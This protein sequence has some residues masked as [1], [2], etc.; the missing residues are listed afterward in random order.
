MLP[1]GTLSFD[2]APFSIAGLE[3]RPFPVCHDSAFCCGFFLTGVDGSIGM[4][5]NGKFLADQFLAE[6]RRCSTIIVKC[7]YEEEKLA[8]EFSGGELLL[9][10]AVIGDVR[11]V[12]Y[13]RTCQAQLG[14][15]VD[16]LLVP[17]GALYTQNGATGVVVVSESAQNFVPVTVHRQENGKAYVSPVQTGLLTAGQTVRLF[18]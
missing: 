5:P 7:G 17:E 3:L 8:S 2:P 6:W 4:V 10:L 1:R 11:D 16:C 14:E 13:M 9:R 12:L 18:K 15:Y